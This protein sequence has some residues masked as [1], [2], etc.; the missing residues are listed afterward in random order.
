MGT[1]TI[2]SMYDTP[3]PDPLPEKLPRRSRAEQARINGAKSR[4]PISK[5]GKATVSQN[6][7]KHGLAAKLLLVDREHEADYNDLKTG[8]TDSLRPQSAAEDLLIDT[9]AKVVWKIRQSDNMECDLLRDNIE[10][11][12]SIHSAFSYDAASLMLL[13]TYQAR[14]ARRLHKL[15]EEFRKVQNEATHPMKTPVSL[16]SAGLQWVAESLELPQETREGN[17]EAHEKISQEQTQILT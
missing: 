10:Q 5:D 16:R 6:A 8:L 3:I 13:S 11:G 15:F 2:R 14:L 12:D 1:I 17:R 4:G 7:R 9:I